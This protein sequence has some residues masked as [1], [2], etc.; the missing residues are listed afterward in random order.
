MDKNK[1]SAIAKEFLDKMNP[2]GWD[3]ADKKP[4]SLNEKIWSIPIGNDTRLEMSFEYDKT[5]G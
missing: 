4:G 3:G 5:C 1:A 2:A